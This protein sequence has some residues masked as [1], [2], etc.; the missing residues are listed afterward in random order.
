MDLR[1]QIIESGMGSD[2]T[3][4]FG[5][6]EVKAHQWVLS[7][8]SEYFTKA[9]NGSFNASSES[10][11]K[12]IELHDDNPDALHG[13]LEMMYGADSHHSLWFYTCVHRADD[14]NNRQ[15]EP[16][17]STTCY[18][19][20][21]VDMYVAARKYLVREAAAET[22]QSLCGQYGP[23]QRETP[24]VSYEVL[25]HIYTTHAEAAFDLRAAVVRRWVECLNQY[26]K[27]PAEQTETAQKLVKE[28]PDFAVDVFTA[29]GA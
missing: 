29:L 18:G 26:S 6:R 23:I 4:R 2:V 14:V 3:L 13:L 25:K 7:A 22:Q 1:P 21:L 17:N 15:L 8:S 10:S 24:S 28:I 11:T 27:G 16:Q 20:Y 19:L 9:F 5:G 12:V